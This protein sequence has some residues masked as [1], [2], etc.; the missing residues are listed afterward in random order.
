MSNQIFHYSNTGIS[1]GQRFYLKDDVSGIFVRNLNIDS[2][3]PILASNLVYNTGNQTVSGTK[4]FAN[5]LEV[6]GTGIFNALDLSNISEFNFSGTNINL[7]NGNVNISGGTLYI[8][9]NAVLTGVNLN[10]YATTAN[11]FATGSTLD[12]KINSLS[13]YVNAQSTSGQVFNT[14]STLDNKI[15][16]LS[17][18]VNSQDNI[19]SGQIFNTGSRLD[20]KINSL[21]GS[22]VLIFGSQAI[23]GTKTFISSSIF[24]NNITVGSNLTVSGNSNITGNST[25]AGNGTFRS[26]VTVLGDLRVTGNITNQGVVL[27][28]NAQT[29]S[30]VKTFL[31]KV[32]LNTSVGP[33]YSPSNDDYRLNIAG[34]VEE[35]ASIQLDSYGG[36]GASSQIMARKARG[37]ATNLSGILKN[38]V[39]FNYAAK[40]Y[41][42]GL[43]GY[44]QNS[45]AQLR[46]T[47]DEDWVARPGYT[48]QGTFITIRTTNIGSPAAIDKVVISTSGLNV[49]DGDIYISGNPVVN[50]TSN[51]TISGNKTFANYLLF[52]N[53]NG[54]GGSISGSQIPESDSNLFINAGGGASYIHLNT[55][56]AS[57]RLGEDGITINP[58][59]EALTIDNADLISINGNAEISA[60]ATIASFKEVS[61]NNLVYNV[62]DQIISGIKTFASRPNVNGTGFLLSGEA[63]AVTL[64][65]TIVYT[66]GDQLISG[67]KTFLNNIN[68]SGTGNFNNVKVSN[69]DKLYLSGVDVLVSNMDNLFLSGVDLVVTG[70]SSIN[71]YNAIYISGNPVLTGVIP[72]SQTIKDVV[73]TTGNQI[74][75]GN[76]TFINNIGVS[77]TG[78]FN[79]IKVSS[80][81]NL[82]LSGIDIIIT[83]NSSINV[84]NDIYISGNPVLTRASISNVVYTTGNQ[85]ISG[86]KTFFDSG[87]FSNGGTPAIP[88]LNNPLSMVGSGNSYLQLN[89]QNR[90]TGSFATA[91]LVITANNGTDNT[92]YI[93]LGINNSGYN[94]PTFSNGTGLDGY[95]F[96]NGGSLDIGTQTPNTA[97]E[98]HAGGTT[99]S[100]VIARISESGLNLVSGNLTVN[101][102]GVL[103]NGQN[104]FTIFMQVTNSNPTNNAISY[105][106]NLPSGPSININN[107]KFQIGEKCI[108]KKA[109]WY[110]YLDTF[111]GIPNQN[112]TGYFINVST[113]STGVISTII[114]ANTF[115][116]SG[117]SYI[118]PITPNVQVNEAD[119][120]VCGLRWGNYTLGFRPSGWRAGVNIYCYN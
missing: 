84:Y 38:D 97:I 41:V 95:L 82:F 59:G 9:G 118:G 52:G 20:N 21:S 106:N 92:N 54:I 4:T 48:G 83:G 90:A 111:T 67:N 61:A 6:Q 58:G 7:I 47:A 69:V 87:V 89:I 65:N 53:Q 100:K 24:N 102:T 101:N 39:I 77:G 70:N 73:Y 11:L 110:Q 40:G 98:F 30:G 107:K 93:N 13:G 68:I 8:S 63:S 2:N 22:S 66:T 35:D 62:N 112:A 23:S 44:S 14:G 36:A 33:G 27:T 86:R 74:I 60:P 29:I 12:S 99:A 104:S 109:S 115:G 49:L 28:R 88:L 75:S 46:F 114:N 76:K 42:S 3:F 79:N 37:T 18:Y 31:D 51:Q 26:N 50:T 19:L 117:F 43:D 15:N 96:V 105:F 32:L 64:P 16:A 94:D 57:M 108:A 25:T 120:V 5:N 34:D 103:L 119:Y 72:S 91:D 78:N 1:S 55:S 71:V 116:A 80:I 45:R 10:A 56:S 81:D 113:E 85:T 17:G